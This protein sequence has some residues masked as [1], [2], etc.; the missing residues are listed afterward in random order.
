MIKA[1]H[2]LLLTAAVALLLEPSTAFAQE[3]FGSRLGVRRG[4]ELFYEPTGS[5]VLFDALDPAVKKWYIPQEL[6][7]EYQWRQQDY[8]NYARQNYER[9]VSTTQEGYYF[10]D[11]YGNYITRGQ[12]IYDWRI[13]APQTAGS[14]LFKTTNFAGW[15]SS[16]VIASDQKG[17]YAYAL[18]IGDRI[19]TTLTPMTFS[20]P[21]F[22]G[23]QLDLAT[24][25]Y[26]ATFL[27]SR[28]SSPGAVGSSTGATSGGGRERSNDTNLI[29][30]RGT[31][32]IGDFVKLG[33]TYLSAFN[34]QTKGQAFEGNPFVGTL[35]EGQNNADVSRIEVRL[36]DDSPEDGIAG[37]AYF[38]EEMIITTTDGG[39][40]SNRRRLGDN[41]IL[42]F[43]PS[44]QGG[45]RRE[46]FLSA[47]GNEVIVL[48]Y[49]LE[50]PEYRNSFGPQPE[51]IKSIEF[52]LLLANDYRI[53]VTSNRQLNA[54]G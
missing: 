39:K 43:H 25:K 13:S 32:Q 42:D 17:Q 47:D 48:V 23:I 14:N 8:T 2:I 3:D 49:D 44:V 10:Y 4:G 37:A 19:R 16:V 53:D 24:D 33:A 52:Q 21:T 46:G 9:Y 30:G 1:K 7:N 15:F 38:Q 20:K 28:P 26:E 50:G 45:F 36:S 35:T 12:L 27:A 6:F 41:N 5:G 51:Q 54:N 22:A 29:G 34:A 40:I 31:V 11:L 18:T